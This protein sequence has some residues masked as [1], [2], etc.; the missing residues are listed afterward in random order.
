MD[1]ER[2]PLI[3]IAGSMIMP[4]LGQI[5]NGE[6]TKGISFFLIFAFVIPVFSYLGVHSP[7]SWLI[8]FVALAVFSGL[9]I[10]AYCIRDAYIS[11]RRIGADYRLQPFNQPYVYLGLVFFGYF[12]VLG[13]LTNYVTHDLLQ[14]FKIPPAAK[15]MAPGI[16]PGDQFFADKRINSPGAQKVRRGDP[17]VF[18]YPNDRTMIYVKRVIGLPGDEV[19]IRGTDVRINGKS[20]RGEEVKDLGSSELNAMLSDHTAYRERGEKGDYTVL[21]KR[22]RPEAPLTFSVPN[23]Q[24][25]VL[26]DNRDN[27]SDSRNFGPVNLTDLIG[28]ARQV[29]FSKGEFGLRLGRIGARLDLNS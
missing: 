23:G 5:Y 19:E 13:Q 20:I 24:V 27:S 21:W 29:W 8:G 22:D 14:A 2:K 16:L 15:S 17:A 4:G 11:A 12:F 26:G 25:F 6:L 1:M 7:S 9:A 10:F 18:V 28:K 3:A